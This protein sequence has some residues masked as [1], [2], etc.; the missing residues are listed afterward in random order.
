MSTSSIP[1]GYKQ[2]VTDPSSTACLERALG[3]LDQLFAAETAN[4]ESR[5]RSRR[6]APPTTSA[7]DVAKA[8][9]CSACRKR[10]LK[11]LPNPDGQDCAR[12]VEGK[13]PCI[14]PELGVR[15]P[16]KGFTKC[17]LPSLLSF[18]LSDKRLTR[19]RTGVIRTQRLL[20]S[21]R[22]DILKVMNGEDS[23]SSSDDSD[24]STPGA[25]TSTRSQ[26]RLDEQGTSRQL[27]DRP[28][29]LRFFVVPPQRAAADLAFVY[30]GVQI[31]RPA[32]Y[33]RHL[34]DDGG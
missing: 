26:G 15:G 31:R 4:Q 6:K 23:D 13:L 11:C 24:S 7:G 28:C 18:R 3:K 5:S 10:K 22:M 21:I 2:P 1:A 33:V 34:D 16:K 19:N 20:N 9:A 12:C 25:S 8:Q 32:Q 30:L 29:V 27:L 17:V 14:W